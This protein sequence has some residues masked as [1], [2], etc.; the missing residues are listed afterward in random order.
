MARCLLP[1]GHRHPLYCSH[2][3]HSCH[4][5]AFTGFLWLHVRSFWNS[6]RVDSARSVLS[7]ITPWT[8]DSNLA[9]TLSIFFPSDVL[10]WGQFPFSIVHF[11]KMSCELI[12]GIQGSNTA[13]HFA[14]CVWAESQVHS[15]QSTTDWTKWQDYYLG[16][17]SGFLLAQKVKILPAMWETHVWSMGQ[18]VGTQIHG[19]SLG[20]GNDNPLPHSCLE[21]SM[22]RGAW[23]ATGHGITKSQTRLSN[24]HIIGMLQGTNV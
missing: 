24:L 15:D 7:S 3:A 19:S 12:S 2:W 21:N 4:S 17:D 23:W 16:S 14:A 8:F 10:F 11:C 18:D 6:S 1:L 20:E 5:A 22:D 9:S 13:S